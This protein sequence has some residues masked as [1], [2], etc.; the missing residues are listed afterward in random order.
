MHNTRLHLKARGWGS[1]P[2]ETHIF[3]NPPFLGKDFITINV[4]KCYG[5]F[6]EIKS[7]K[8]Y[9]ISFRASHLPHNTL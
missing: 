9:D 2:P 8:I 5:G 1:D 3:E 6:F 4:K 7:E